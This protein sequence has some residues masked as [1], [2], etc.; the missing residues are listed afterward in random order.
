MTTELLNLELGPSFNFS[1]QVHPLVPLTI[2][3]LFYRN[4]GRKLVGTLLG[5]IYPNHIEITNCFGLPKDI[6]E[7]VDDAENE[8]L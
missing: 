5:S 8:E 1:V 4:K 3:E 2:C 6:E 7:N